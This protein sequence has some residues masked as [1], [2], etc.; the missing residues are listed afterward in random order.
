[1]SIPQSIDVYDEALVDLNSWQLLHPV[2]TD[3]GSGMGI[4]HCYPEYAYVYSYESYAGSSICHSW[5]PVYEAKFGRVMAFAA[6]IRWDVEVA[7]MY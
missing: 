2:T 3:V 4:S 7:G 1:M 5:C 6:A